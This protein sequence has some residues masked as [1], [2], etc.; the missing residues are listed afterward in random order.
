[1]NTQFI[2]RVLPTLCRNAHIKFG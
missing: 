1:M 2:T